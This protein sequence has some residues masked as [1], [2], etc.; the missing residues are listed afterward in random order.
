MLSAI[1]LKLRRD[2]DAFVVKVAA[3][4]KIP[5]TM[6]TLLEDIRYVLGGVEEYVSTCFVVIVAND[7]HP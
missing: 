1:F 4:V 3:Q 2:I 6:K 5:E 7:E